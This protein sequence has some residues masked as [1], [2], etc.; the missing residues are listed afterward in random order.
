M[1]VGRGVRVRGRSRAPGILLALLLA[2]VPAQAQDTTR[3]PSDTA[4]APADTTRRDTTRRDTTARA[5]RRTLAKAEALPLD[6]PRAARAVNGLPPRALA[7]DATELLARVPGTFRYDLGAVGGAHGISVQ[8]RSPD[9]A[10]LTLDGVPF[11]DLLTG[12]PRYDLLPL[13]FLDTL[14]T[15]VSGSPLG[16]PEAVRAAL[17][18]Y[19]YARPLTTL[20]YR[21]G[22]FQSIGAL[23]TQ[24]RKVRF[25][26][27]PAFAQFTGGYF[28]RGADNLD[29]LPNNSAELRSERR[30]LGRVRYR[31][32]GWG[33]EVTVLHNRRRIGAGGGVALEAGQPP[34]IAFTPRRTARYPDARRRLLRTDLA[35]TLRLRDLTEGV[36]GAPPDSLSPP[37]AAGVPF[38][39]TVYRT[40]Q[41]HRYR[42]PDLAG[43]F[44]VDTTA[45]PPLTPGT[46][47]ADSLEAATA[48]YGL[49]LAT[50]LELRSERFGRHA[51]ALKAHAWRDAF[52]GGNALPDDAA[53]THLH[54]SARD[55]TRLAGLAAVLSAGLH[56]GPRQTYPSASV[57]LAAP[58]LDGAVDLFAEAGLSGQSVS[59]VEAQGLGTPG[60]RLVEPLAGDREPGSVLTAEAGARATLGP[61]RTQ[62]TL[63]GERTSR[64][65][66]LR[67]LDRAVV[68]R[69]RVAN[70]SSR[71]TG[72][73]LAAR[74]RTEAERGFYATA[75]GT[76]YL[77]ESTP[78]FAPA[79]APSVPQVH[80][81][82]RL[83]AR[84]A[85]FTDD[86]AVD[87]YAEGHLWSRMT[88]R[89]LHGPTGRL[90]HPPPGSPVLGPAGTLDLHAEA[91]IRTATLFFSYENALADTQVQRG[92]LGAPVY[93]L[94]ARRFRFGVYWPIFN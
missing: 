81:R 34:A 64:R 25:F 26:G 16:T 62:L 56:T 91:Q 37:T 19:D 70:G 68:V 59:W 22:G 60:I 54:L 71:R 86:L 75:T 93:P 24:Q 47:D 79:A 88:G 67:A 1:K 89:T 52:T 5:P 69:A 15:Q 23:H 2:A 17:R 3:A 12:R 49:R 43:T 14:R 85:F 61:V 27:V 44:G 32:R 36:A 63:F 58:A 10:A 8:A 50:R 28:G 87:A 40:S 18:P 33:A 7:L 77:D 80:G 84:Y 6:P 35:A 92:V 74:W 42:N 39:A 78:P 76:A 41:T 94:P 30:L 45:A 9:Q 53:R 4:R 48:R 72:A 38:T 46:F 55:S 83:G 11:D 66:Y 82:A 31:R 65:L 57:R 29:V 51:L 21:S 20:R 13:P 90:V 73:S